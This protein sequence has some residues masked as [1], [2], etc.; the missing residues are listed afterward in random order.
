MKMLFDHRSYYDYFVAVL[1]RVEE[2]LTYDGGIVSRESEKV[3][4]MGKMENGVFNG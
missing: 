1:Y 4:E 2:I 3:N